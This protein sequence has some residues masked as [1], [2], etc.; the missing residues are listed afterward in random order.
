MSS[1]R[2]ALVVLAVLVLVIVPIAS[3]ANEQAFPGDEGPRGLVPCGDRSDGGLD[4][5]CQL[6]HLVALGQDLISLAIF[7]SVIIATIVVVWAGFLY[8]TAGG[9]PGK[10]STAHGLFGKVVIGF[11]IVLTAWFVVDTLMKAL[12]PGKAGDVGFGPWNQ[13]K[14]TRDPLLDDPG[15]ISGTSVIDVRVTGRQAKVRRETENRFRLESAQVGTRSNEDRISIN[16]PMCEE[17]QVS[18]CTDVGGLK[19]TT[20]RTI[21]DSARGCAEVNV[22]IACD[23][24][25]TGG[26]EVGPHACAASTDTH[27]TGDKF[28]V[29]NT[30]SIK[31]YLVNDEH[32][33]KGVVNGRSGRYS[34][35]GSTFWVLEDEGRDNEHQDV[36]AISGR[37]WYEDLTSSGEELRVGGFTTKSA[38]L[39]A[40]DADPSSTKIGTREERGSLYYQFSTCS[41]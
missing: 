30:P 20:V 27:C 12:L 39:Q 23:F 22:G 10:I 31:R 32:F 25:I 7:V 33:V 18:N 36:L 16:K 17:G 9:D 13:V 4:S 3:A 6:C 2:Y 28:D 8:L 41:N 15:Y 37:Y 11:L 29:R 38:C 5:S 21:L 19:D 35:D 14:C 26:S 34:T 1:M 40:F 24:V